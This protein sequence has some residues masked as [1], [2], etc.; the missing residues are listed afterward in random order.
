[1]INRL[2]ALVLAS[3]VSLLASSASAAPTPNAPVDDV[4]AEPTTSHD[5]WVARPIVVLGH[6]QTLGPLG[7]FGVSAEYSFNPYFS[8]GLGVGTNGETQG[9]AMARFRLPLDDHFGAG[10]GVGAS[11]GR[12]FKLDLCF[13]DPCPTPERPPAVVS[14]DTELFVEGRTTGGF[15]ARLYGGVH[16]Q[17]DGDRRM[18]GYFGIGGGWAF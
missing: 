13:W 1:M 14:G 3:S 9:Q 17:I 12:P 4:A 5:V 2:T 6:V 11:Y 8:A 10:V 16:Q 18:N 15:T 7:V